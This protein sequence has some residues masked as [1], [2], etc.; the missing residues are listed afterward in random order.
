MIYTAVTS[1]RVGLE[2]LRNKQHGDG[3]RQDIHADP[4]PPPH[5]WAGFTAG[6]QNL[7]MLAWNLI[8]D[9]PRRLRTL[10]MWGNGHLY[11]VASGSA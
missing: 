10:P 3:K 1:I 6:L 7:G 5:A 9:G 4:S 8:N 11:S 2:R